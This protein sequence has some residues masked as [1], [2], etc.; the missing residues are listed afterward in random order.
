MTQY[1]FSNLPEQLILDTR[2]FSPQD[3]VDFEPSKK[4]IVER[5]HASTQ[6]PLIHDF[7]TN[8]GLVIFEPS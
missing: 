7:V 4:G 6:F 3:C 2:G 8:E 5:H 1:T